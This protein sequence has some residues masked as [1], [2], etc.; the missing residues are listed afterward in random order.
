LFHSAQHI[1]FGAFI[2]FDEPYLFDTKRDQGIEWTVDHSPCREEEPDFA[3]L[4]LRQHYRLGYCSNGSL[5]VAPHRKYRMV[6]G[7]DA[8]NRYTM[9][10][11]WQPI[12]APAISRH[13][14]LQG[15]A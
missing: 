13:T 8:S 6:Q 1:Q 5:D 3:V 14:R 11:E 10:S 15:L 2:D 4:L 12:C 9:Q 7:D